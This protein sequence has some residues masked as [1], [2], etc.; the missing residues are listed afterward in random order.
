MWRWIGIACGRCATRRPGGG[1]G[2][3]SRQAFPSR[4]PSDSCSPQSCWEAWQ[5]ATSLPEVPGGERNW[6]YR[7]SWVRD[8]TLAARAL[9]ELGFDAEADDFRKFIQRSAA[10]HVD[11]L[12]IAYGVEGERRLGE[13]VLDHLQGYGG[14]QPVHV[15]NDAATQIQNDVLGELMLLAWRWHTRGHAPDDD[16]WRF[17]RDLADA[18]A[19]RWDDPDSGIWELRDRPEHF[20]HSKVMCWAAL[21]RALA[22][23]DECMRRAPTVRWRKA[24]DAARRAIERRGFDKRRGTFVRSFGSKQVDAALLLLPH[25]GFVSADDERMVGTVDAIREDLSEDGLLRRYR[26]DDGLPGKEGVFLPASF[27]LAECLAGQ[28]RREEAQ[29][30]FDTAAATAN[31]LG[32]YSEEY[33]PA[34]G[35]MLGNFPQ[36]LTHLSHIAAGAALRE[37]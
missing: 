33:D 4:R 1:N 12:Q 22:L 18:A 7:Y 25:A 23:A 29:G 20:V 17:L 10:G 13:Q 3:R 37:R 11:D 14:A 36:A 35:S 2:G 28:G 15:G 31:D 26:A 5:T 24:R 6:D 32:L 8:S 34:S 19:E 27:W 16:M 30:V 21:D 9:A